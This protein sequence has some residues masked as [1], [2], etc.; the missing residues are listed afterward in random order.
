MTA[1]KGLR[2][3]LEEPAAATANPLQTPRDEAYVSAGSSVG[4][5]A[6]T[7]P[8]LSN[9][10]VARALV[11]PGGLGIADGL[12]NDLPPTVS[13][14]PRLVGSFVHMPTVLQNAQSKTPDPSPIQDAGQPFV[15]ATPTAQNAPSGPWISE[16]SSQF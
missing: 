12:S 15:V 16:S 6:G 7:A 8:L 2:Q 4:S 3:K 5:N 11:T 14:H 9:P 10:V 13:R 1:I